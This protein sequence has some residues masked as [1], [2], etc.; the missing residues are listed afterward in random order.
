M[1]QE[2][3]PTAVKLAIKHY[4]QQMFKDWKLSLPAIILPG[5]GSIFVFYIPPLIVAKILAN[6][7]GRSDIHFSEFLPYILLFA[8]IWSIGE[9][10]WRTGMVFLARAEVKG[11]RRLYSNALNFLLN[12]DLAFFHSNFAGSL[13]KK[14]IG[15][16]RRY[17]EFLDV[18]AF[19]I[20][21]DLV[22]M[23][24]ALTTSPALTPT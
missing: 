14:A 22:P 19:T 8:G 16:A 10:L 13:T 21:P 3:N 24:F 4:R 17:E 18:M 23:I 20:M 5:I 6:F 7:S 1:Q 15:Y 9:I 12:R 2:R 11:M